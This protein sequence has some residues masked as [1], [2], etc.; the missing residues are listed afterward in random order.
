MHMYV[1]WWYLCIWTLAVMILLKESANWLH[2]SCS[3]HTEA[4]KFSN[5]DACHFFAVCTSV[6]MQQ[7]K[8]STSKG[9]HGVCFHSH[10]SSSTITSFTI[11]GIHAPI[12]YNIA[13]N[14]GTC[15]IH[16][17]PSTIIKF[18]KLSWAVYSV[19]GHWAMQTFPYKLVAFACLHKWDFLLWISCKH[20]AFLLC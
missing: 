19:P 4:L 17:R 16:W 20:W 1:L 18:G 9:G 15:L 14:K 7:A 11:P 10:H 5:D 8:H 2:Y 6:H 3:L 12:R 13:L